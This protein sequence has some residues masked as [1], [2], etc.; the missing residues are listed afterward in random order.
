METLI[1]WL[2]CLAI[3]NGVWVVVFCSPLIRHVI[4]HYVELEEELYTSTDVENFFLARKMWFAH[5]LWTCAT[6]QAVWTAAFATICF[7][8]APGISVWASPIIFLAT[9]PFAKW[10]QKHLR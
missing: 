8:M 1:N 7:V 9:L 3:A 6:C 5:N 10:T 2:I 4:T